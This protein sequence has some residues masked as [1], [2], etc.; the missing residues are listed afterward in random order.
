MQ[1]FFPRSVTPDPARPP[2]PDV[3]PTTSTLPDYQLDNHNHHSPKSQTFVPYGR[4]LHDPYRH[5]AHMNSFRFPQQHSMYS[6][7]RP[8]HRRY[9]SEG[10]EATPEYESD[11]ERPPFDGEDAIAPSWE[12]NQSHSNLHHQPR[13][14]RQD[15]ER[16]GPGK[17]P[18]SPATMEEGG[19]NQPSTLHP[20]VR[21][22]H[23][24]HEIG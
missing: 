17:L 19:H 9:L 2:T 7:T 18:S 13:N 5:E 10:G 21:I 24:L 15:L 14:G 3:K 1:I 11:P 6:L 20:Y 8:Q 23:F 4:H 12:S 22:F 16:E